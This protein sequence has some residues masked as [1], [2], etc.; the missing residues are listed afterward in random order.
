[1]KLPPAVSLTNLLLHLHCENWVYAWLICFTSRGKSNPLKSFAVF[2]A[3]A[4]KF[5]MKFYRFMWLSYLHLIAERHLII[6]I[7]DEVIDILARPLSDFRALKNVRAETVKRA[8]RT[9]TTQWTLWQSLCVL[10]LF[11]ASFCASLQS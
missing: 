3:T 2:S 9:E 1:M 4:W 6:F 8:S 10:E 5:S 7:Y 11:T